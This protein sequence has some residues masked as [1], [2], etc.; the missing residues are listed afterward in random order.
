MLN[1]HKLMVFVAAAQAGSLSAAAT[2]LYITQSSV[3]QHIRDL[4]AALGVKLFERRANGVTLTA[5]GQQLLEQAL[6]LLRQAAEIE[7]S[8]MDV[9][10]V[11]A[12][13]LRVGATPGVSAYL[14]PGWLGAFR[15][16]HPNVETI[17]TTGTTDSITDQVGN[18]A[19][20]VGITE[21]NPTAAIDQITY[22]E[23]VAFEQFA[24]VGSGHPWR[25]RERVPLAELTGHCLITRQPGSHS[26]TWLENV[27]IRHSVRVEVEAAFDGLEAIKQTIVPSK[28]CFTVLPLYTVSAEVAAGQ[29]H[30]LSI[31]DV[32]LSRSLWLVTNRHIPLSPFAEA[33]LNAIR[34]SVAVG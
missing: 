21:G 11:K 33:F 26:R 25:E 32:A 17:L 3:S 22:E 4:E 30:P 15:E 6:P 24:I 5:P 23:L 10:Q 28:R 34:A 16:E 18:H 13:K 12:G 14:A 31:E 27:L 7:R 19:L 20:D 1:L 9:T 2:H 8:L 29:L